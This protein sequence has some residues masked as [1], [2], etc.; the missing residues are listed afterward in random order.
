[1]HLSYGPGFSRNPH[2]AN[3]LLRSCKS[4]GVLIASTDCIINV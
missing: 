2:V 3:A 1:M 4:G